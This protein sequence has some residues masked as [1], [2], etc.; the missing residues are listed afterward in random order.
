M[1]L[2]HRWNQFRTGCYQWGERVRG[3]PEAP[4]VALSSTLVGLERTQVPGPRLGGLFALGPS[5]SLDGA[6]GS[7][8]PGLLGGL[9]LIEGQTQMVL[10]VLKGEEEPSHRLEHYRR[11]LQGVVGN[12][13]HGSKLT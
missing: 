2:W 11:L 1:V 5:D 10:Q 13:A 8:E 6:Q 9:N 7:V 3:C 4:S 12:C